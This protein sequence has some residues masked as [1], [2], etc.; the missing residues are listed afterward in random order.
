MYWGYQQRQGQQALQQGLLAL[1]N[2]DPATAVA[3]F[4]TAENS[5]AEV[6]SR[7]L[8]LWYLGE[9]YTAQ[10]QKEAAFEAYGKVASGG[11]KAN[12][13]EALA[14]FKLGQEAERSGDIALA[15]QRYEGAAGIES[16]VKGDSLL[17]VARV[18]EKAKDSQ[19]ARGAYDKFLEEFSTAPMAEVV[20]QK[21]G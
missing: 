16:P 14:L 6:Q 5:F 21:V 10:S 2:K 1:Q 15:R 19:A 3:H 4:Q 18:A 8:A 13:L 11:A 17:A 7:Q 9:A 20:R 12:Y